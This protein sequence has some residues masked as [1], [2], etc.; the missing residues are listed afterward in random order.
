MRQFIFV[1]LIF[2]ISCNENHQTK[3]NKILSQSDKR[4]YATELIENGFLKYADS[5][6]I[7]HLK[8][9]ITNSFN[10]YNDD[11]YK[12]AH[13]DAEALAEFNFDFF[14]PTLNK[15]LS[16]RD[17]NLTV[18]KLNNKAVFGYFFF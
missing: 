16:K 6:K 1:I 3:D 17:I 15:I 14:L 8:M 12:I 2:L 4:D 18:K 11:N 13:I 9:E 10:I 7:N 5:L